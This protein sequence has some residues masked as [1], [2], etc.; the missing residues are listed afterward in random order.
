MND[1]FPVHVERLAEGEY[2]LRW[3]ED[4]SAGP[5]RVRVHAEPAQARHARPVHE[6]ARGE[7]RVGPGAGERHYFHLEPRDGE[8]LTAAQRDVPLEGGTNFRDMGGYRAA[9]RRRVRWGRLFRSGHSAGL[10]ERDRDVVAALGIAVCCDFR[11]DEERRIEPTRL[12]ATTRIVGLPIDPGSQNSFFARIA[13][14][15]A[16]PAQMALFMEQ[17]NREFARTHTAV[18][19]RM[20]RE[21]LE[22]DTGA[23]MINCAAGK[24]RTGFGAAM[25]LAALGVGERDIMA[26][27]ML[28][29]RYF[30]I[31]REL[32]RVQRKYGG[33]MERPLDLALIMPMLETRE[34]YLGAALETIRAEFGGLD[35]YLEQILGIGAP[36]RR[37]LR[38][39]YTA[40]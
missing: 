20:F 5:V 32:A 22:L 13:T 26:D 34:S 37:E 12:P 3:S 1:V 19:R 14:G 15:E 9:D 24:D 10:S 36:E 23:F 21:L 25:I 17:I 39:R 38:A 8:A 31:E 27:Y 7:L 33:A 2:L 16:G 29:A 11:R 6:E 4:F 18:Y 35:S 30:P 40:A 28:S